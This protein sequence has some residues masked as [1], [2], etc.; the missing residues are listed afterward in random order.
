V[1]RHRPADFLPSYVLARPDF[2]R[3]CSTRDLGMVLR[4]AVRWGGAG[5]SASHL[6]RRCELTVSRVQDY[7]SGRMTAQRVEIFERVSDGLHIPGQMF[8]LGQRP[9]EEAAHA[10]SADLPARA[11]DNGSP[12]SPSKGNRVVDSTDIG[13]F[14]ADLTAS[15]TSNEVIGR[16]D[17]AVIALA[18]MHTQ[19]PAKRLLG[20]A[21]QLH[22]QA[23][24]LLRGRLRLSQRRDLFRIESDLLA[25]TCLL[26]GDINRDQAAEQYGCVALALAQEAGSNQ[27]VART[28]LAKTLRWRE[29]FVESADMA[30]LGFEC[31][32]VS[33]VRTQLASQEANAAALL[34]DGRRA[35]DAL[36]RAEEAAEVAPSDSGVTAWSFPTA[37]QA[38]FALSVA[39]HTG[40]PHAALR[41][42]RLA[43]EGWAAGEPQVVANWA[44]I[45][46]GAGL[47]HLDLG[48][49]DAAVD[50]ATPVL[51]LPPELR[52]ATVTGYTG[53]LDRRLAH[54]R[55]R[56]SRLASDFRRKIR[57]FNA[58]ALLTE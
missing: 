11:K 26:L 50:E 27:A 43:D 15:T 38:I 30:R 14:L 24:D 7:I 19:V 56:S 2:V 49:L 3:A 12:M 40:D 1:A 25:H 57:E 32:P 46:V 39:A 53:N 52:V 28:A 41:A 10:G 17:R 37:R 21:S 58:T 9:W 31:S 23:Q 29:R 4:L 35:H 55:F 33:T 13:A 47:A 45:R 5:F 20:Q 48:D 34:G 44:Q 16:L 6:A 8:D 51:S 22:R 42:A 18:E 36:R 54:S